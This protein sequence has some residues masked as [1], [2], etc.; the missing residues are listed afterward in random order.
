VRLR[1]WLLLIQLPRITP[2]IQLPDYVIRYRASLS[3]A[4]A[5]LQTTND[6]AG[7]A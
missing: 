3:L 1:R 5:M 4:Q 6:L 2:L 7:A